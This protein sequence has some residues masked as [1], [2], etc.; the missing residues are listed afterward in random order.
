MSGSQWRIDLARQ[1]SALYPAEAMVLVGSP[2]F[3][4]ADAYSDIDVVMFWHDIPSDDERTKI[5]Q[6]YAH[7]HVVDSFNHQAEFSLQDAAEVLHAG[8]NKLKLDIT[9]K[10]IAAQNQMIEE[11]V[12]GL[13]TNLKK[14]VQI[15]NIDKGIV[16]KGK[17]QFEIWRNSYHPMPFAL[18]EK[19]LAEY[20]HFW[21]YQPLQKLVIERDDPLFARQLMNDSCEKIIKALCV[22]NG[23]YPPDK[24]KHL[25]Y[26]LKGLEQASA[27][28]ERIQ[29][30]C[31]YPLDQA[32]HSLKSLIEDVFD[33]ADHFGYD[34]H[35]ARQH[36]ATVR[37]AN[38]EAITIIKEQGL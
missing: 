31:H 11:V 35:K 24:S 25:S 6:S 32:H 30:I 38:K 23:Q 12:A 5:G 20:L 9:H 34:T 4:L 27:T 28:Y 33:W 7:V 22:M 36:Y 17:S 19:L 18:A 13:D 10:S 15:R 14:L 3:G 21:A 37:H 16:F 1:I 8:D 29:Q 26:L 2:A